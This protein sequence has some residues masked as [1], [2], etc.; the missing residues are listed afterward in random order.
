MDFGLSDEQKLLQANLRRYLD[1]RL[2]VARARKAMEGAEPDPSVWRELAEL[3]VAGILIPEEH[4]GSGLGVLDAA[5]AAE[6]LAWGAVPAPFLG[7]AVLAPVLLREA[8]SREQQAA[9]LPRLATGEARLSVAAEEVLVRRGGRG[10]ELRDG[11]I[12]GRALFAVDSAGAEGFL[13]ALPGPAVALVPADAPGLRVEPRET[14]DRSRRFAELF[15]D[16]VRPGEVLAAGARAERALHRMLLAGFAVLAADLL[17]ASER[18]LEMS[19]AYA[20]E[21]QQFGRVIASFQAVKHLCAEMAAELEPARALVWHAAHAVDALPD[22]AP[23]LAAH[24]KAHLGEVGRTLVRTATEVHGGI[25]FTDAYDLHLWFKRVEV[26]RALLGTPERVREWAA[27][28]QGWP[29]V[30]AGAGAP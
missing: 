2:P 7:S 12:H 14:H 24:A 27:A 25:G 11:A 8:A 30:A 6:V 13:V 9:W 4:G 15:F 29:P 23:L 21:R 10:V 5:V 16:A 3:G 17:G 26:D 1:E 22:E 28:W 20:G 19:V 18:A